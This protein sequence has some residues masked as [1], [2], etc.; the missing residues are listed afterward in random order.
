MGVQ[1]WWNINWQVKRDVFQKNFLSTTCCFKNLKW[2]AL[3]SNRSIRNEKPATDYWLWHVSLTNRQSSTTNHCLEFNRLSATRIP[4]FKMNSEDR[5]NVHNNSR[6][7]RDV[8]NGPATKNC[9]HFAYPWQLVKL[10]PS[11]QR[12]QGWIYCTRSTLLWET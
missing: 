7:L 9:L 11:G 6:Q 2:T 8:H 10:I 4:H 12:L 1:N 5:Y 3:E